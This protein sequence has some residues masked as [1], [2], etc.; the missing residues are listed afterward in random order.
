MAELTSEGYLDLSDAEKDS[1]I[2]QF[3][4]GL[5]GIASGLIKVPEGVISLGAELIDLGLDTNSAAQVEQFFDDINPFE[6][7]AAE[8]AA[9][10][11]TE[12]LVQVGIPGAIG[13]KT[14]TK[15]ADKALKAKKASNYVNFKN[16]NLIKAAGKASDLNRKAKAKRFAAGVT[17]GA[18]GEA[19][20]AD[21]EK[22][23]TFGDLF[24]GPTQLDREEETSSD[25]A[26]ASRKLFNR[27]KF[28]SESI[29]VTPF[30]YG[31]G[32]A[33]KAA[34]TRGKNIEFSNSKL[35]R[36][37]NKVFSALRARGAKPQQIFED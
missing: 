29:L 12:A 32:K 9:G 26:D 20:V 35:D 33:I 1:E 14:A 28:G 17:G 31:A 18:A 27:L 11:I 21:V 4:A 19:F 23:G 13:F 3:E 37:F 10:R 34:A 2:S 5:A 8:K 7:I 16:P 25:S 22:I 6:D 30:V 24:G 36:Y 15:L